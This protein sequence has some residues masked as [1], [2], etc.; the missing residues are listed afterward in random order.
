MHYS[1]FLPLVTLLASS[2]VEASSTAMIEGRAVGLVARSKYTSDAPCMTAPVSAEPDY[3]YYTFH[4]NAEIIDRAIKAGLTKIGVLQECRPN[5]NGK[6][7]GGNTRN[8]AH[9][10][11][12]KFVLGS[13]VKVQVKRC[14]KG[15][16][17]PRGKSERIEIE[18]RN[19]GTTDFLDWDV[20]M[21][22]V[23]G[24]R[25]APVLI[26]VS[27]RYQAIGISLKADYTKTWTTI[28]T[29][30]ITYTVP[31]GYYGTIISQ[32]WTHRVSGNVYMSCGTD[33]WQKGTFMANSHTSQNYGGMDWVTG[34]MRLCASKTYPI[35]YCEGS[36]SHH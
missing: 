12:D 1:Q 14:R 26:A 9:V 35:P 11:L 3:S 6:W 13:P 32:P 5:G 25:Q 31:L 2:V 24:A 23:W 30:T 20:Q 28:D 34:V 29:T 18:N 15:Y 36:G 7:W 21:S 8:W 17:A 4:I 19:T 22:A 16:V 27:H 33:N 10:P